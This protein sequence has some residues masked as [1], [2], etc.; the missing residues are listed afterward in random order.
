MPGMEM[1]FRFTG[2]NKND[3]FHQDMSALVGEFGFSVKSMKPKD[4][5]CRGSCKKYYKEFKAMVEG[6]GKSIAQ[7][8]DYFLRSHKGLAIQDLVR[9]QT[10]SKYPSMG[11][12]VYWGDSGDAMT[13]MHPKAVQALHDAIWLYNACGLRGRYG[14]RPKE[15][16]RL[17]FSTLPLLTRPC[18]TGTMV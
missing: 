7:R 2:V 14:S 5:A 10:E 8:K 12:I 18:M 13:N 4:S 1:G 11:N 15:S 3:N 16:S 9:Y 6:S 17:R